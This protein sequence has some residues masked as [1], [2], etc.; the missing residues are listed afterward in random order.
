MHFEIIENN[1][2]V[3]K[4]LEE[5][6]TESFF[7]STIYVESA[8]LPGYWLAPHV[9]NETTNVMVYSFETGRH[10]YVRRALFYPTSKRSIF[11]PRRPHR[12]EVLDCGD[13]A[14]CLR[15]RHLKLE[16]LNH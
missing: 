10:W 7:N 5:D 16:K 8:D 9:V 15:T 3:H 6:Y 4:F 14:A 13:G 1:F 2:S 11:D 12:I